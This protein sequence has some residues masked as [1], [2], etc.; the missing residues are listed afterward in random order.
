MT[1]CD[2]VC[3]SLSAGADLDAEPFSVSGSHFSNIEKL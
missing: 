3:V 1:F 2:S